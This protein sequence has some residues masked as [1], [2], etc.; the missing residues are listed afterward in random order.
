MRLMD[1]IIL[2]PKGRRGSQITVSCWVPYQSYMI[3]S[4]INLFANCEIILNVND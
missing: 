3:S 2:Q 1:P 4:D